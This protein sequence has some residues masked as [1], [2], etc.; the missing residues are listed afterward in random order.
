MINKIL[1]QKESHQI[2]VTALLLLVALL[3]LKFSVSN[4]NLS[5]ASS[6]ATVG[7]AISGTAINFSTY[8]GYW[9][10]HMDAY[11][12]SKEEEW[13]AGVIGGSVFLSTDGGRT[14]VKK[15]DKGLDTTFTK[16]ALSEKEG[17]PVILAAG[18]VGNYDNFSSKIFVTTDGGQNWTESGQIAPGQNWLDVNI[19]SGT[20]F[21]TAIVQNDKI[22]VSNDYGIT[23]SPVTSGSIYW[24]ASDITDDGKTIIAAR[25]GSSAL[26]IFTRSSISS[27]SW[28]ERQVNPTG[29]NS[30]YWRYL[31][32]SNDGKSIQAYSNDMYVSADSGASWKKVSDFVANNWSGSDRGDVLVATLPSPRIS[33]KVTLNNGNSWESVNTINSQ[34]QEQAGVSAV[35]D[36][37]IYVAG[38]IVGQ[39][40]GRLFV[41]ALP[42]KN[43]SFLSPLS[44][45][46]LLTWTP[47]IIW[48][49]S[50]PQDKCEYK[51]NSSSYRTVDCTR[52]GM[53]LPEP[54]PG[55]NIDLS[56]RNSSN[57]KSAFTES[58]TFN[59]QPINWDKDYP[60]GLSPKSISSED[61]SRYFYAEGNSIAYSSDYGK[62]WTNIRANLP[63]NESVSG[64]AMTLDGK[65]LF[66]TTT[67]SNT[68]KSKIFTSDTVNNN[69]VTWSEIKYNGGAF[70]AALNRI[71][72]S[73]DGQYQIVGATDGVYVSKNNGRNWSKNLSIAF[74]SSVAISENGRNMIASNTAD[75]S[76]IYISKDYGDS[77]Q[78]LSLGGLD[79]R[80]RNGAISNDGQKIFV[81]NTGFGAYITTNSGTN[82]SNLNSININTAFTEIESG[83]IIAGDHSSGE[84]GDIHISNN[85]GKSFEKISDLGYKIKSVYATFAGDASR[86]LLTINDT[87]S[88]ER[89]AMICFNGPCRLVQTDTTPPSI[90]NLSPNGSL[91]SGTTNVMLS[92][93]TNED[94]T[95]RY[96]S[97]SNSDFSNMIEMDTSNNR[98]H[99]KAISG[100]ANGSSYNY[101]FKCRDSA[102]NTGEAQLNFSVAS[103]PQNLVPSVALSNSSATLDTTNQSYNPTGVFTFNVNVS[104]GSQDI[105]VIKNPVM[106]TASTLEA[107][108]SRAIRL[109]QLGSRLDLVSGGEVVKDP[110]S[111]YESI[112][113]SANTTATVAISMRQ[114]NRSTSA[115]SIVYELTGIRYTT[116]PW[117]LVGDAESTQHKMISIPSGSMRTEAITLP[118]RVVA[119]A[120]ET[121]KKL[122]S[123]SILGSV[124]DGIKSLINK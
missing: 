80:M 49:Y 33:L 114:F 57:N 75:S 88:R 4:L 100:L 74:W 89:L 25:T 64:F 71:D 34:V 90:D 17:K 29:N 27:N 67:N 98:S 122:E 108:S 22:Y 45:Q 118:G 63:E 46:N 121:E 36:K 26:S 76:N 51:Y 106:F 123:R 38:N 68:Q 41:S 18:I 103:A 107:S 65:K 32:I 83:L 6:T 53:D 47:S 43:L 113:I 21:V 30:T 104:A 84:T 37:F 95:C 124:L 85:Y 91:S 78:T 62:T 120:I 109:M 14:I 58:V 66:L 117:V 50:N 119:G 116:K 28:S 23:L 60:M 11:T 44:N 55:T 69:S 7:A 97:S 102:M 72:V 111:A 24:M 12:S 59:Y 15:L 70:P 1:P 52:F 42:E 54:T 9:F 16:V 101:H 61:G 31:N 3:G 35:S 92:L 48:K 5:N 2:I 94:A 99:S 96:S 40:I 19:A 20:G 105:Y 73:A 8:Q 10:N 81:K 115:Q 39:G 13:V 56:I 77:W 82:W 110:K 93:N 112:K 79:A 87:N 86:A